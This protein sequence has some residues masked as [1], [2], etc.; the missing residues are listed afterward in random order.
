MQASEP[1]RSG[2]QPA[3][4][5]RISAPAEDSGPCGDVAGADVHAWLVD[6][7]ATA[8]LITNRDRLAPPDLLAACALLSSAE[9]HRA[10]SYLWPRDGMRFAA[11]RAWLRVILSRCL[12]VDVQDLRFAPAA[13][14]R[15][16]LAAHRRGALHY[17][18]S[19]SG[20]RCLVAVSRSPVGADIE[21]LDVRAGLA[22]LVTGRFAPAEA[23]CLAAGCGGTKLRGFY[24]HWTAKE[25]FL[26]ATGI[27][28][29]GVRD[30]AL[31]CGERPVIEF[32]SRPAPCWTVSFLEP[33][34]GY[35]ATVVSVGPVTTVTADLQPTS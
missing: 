1:S 11:S 32:A 35:V 15:P 34:A 21:R 30:T 7:D 20:G 33:A 13:D 16:A 5:W 26:K 19:R 2:R 4:S 25:A 24:R 27:G 29:T 31:L 23:D 28:L 12:A 3:E 17:S 6:L 14:G 10:A 18:L 9:R 22:D 8:D